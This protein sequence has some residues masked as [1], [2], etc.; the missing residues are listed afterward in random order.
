MMALTVLAEL[1]LAYELSNAFKL[2]RAFSLG[3]NIAFRQ[4]RAKPRQQLLQVLPFAEFLS[5]W[6]KDQGRPL[7][8]EF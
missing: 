7:M 4:P 2:E 8:Q 3:I 5:L 6:F 1:D